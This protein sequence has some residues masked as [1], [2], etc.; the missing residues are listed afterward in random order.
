M[1]ST[2]YLLISQRL[3][4][5]GSIALPREREGGGWP[6]G[7]TADKVSENSLLIGFSC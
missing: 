2:S 6:S 7:D 3:G 5:L 1:I 4:D